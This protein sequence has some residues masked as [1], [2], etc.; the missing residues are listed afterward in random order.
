MIIHQIHQVNPQATIIFTVSPVRHIKDGFVEN[1]QSKAHL[2]SAIHNVVSHQSESSCFYF[3]S[4]E[5][6][7]DE[8][9]DYRFYADDMIHPNQTAINYIWEKFQEVWMST[10]SQEI[11]NEVQAIQNGLAH[12][13]FN[14]N[15][16][17]HLKFVE[18][19]KSKIKIIQNKF[20]HITF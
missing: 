10:E 15:S 4:Y 2:I 7:M 11:M 3:P 20:P 1:T 9:R 8:L 6:M 13:P 19:L 16:E 14:P 12:R 5:I 17:A 18:Q